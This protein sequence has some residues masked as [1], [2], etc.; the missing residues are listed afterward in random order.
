[1]GWNL[2]QL[3][4]CNNNC[5]SFR[6]LQKAAGTVICWNVYAVHWNKS[7]KDGGIAPWKDLNKNKRKEKEKQ[8]LQTCA[9]GC[10]RKREVLLQYAGI[11]MMHWNNHKDSFFEDQRWQVHLMLLQ[12]ELKAAPK[13][14]AEWLWRPPLFHKQVQITHRQWIHI[15]SQTHFWGVFNLLLIGKLE[16]NATVC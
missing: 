11:S 16:P 12:G 2:S 6:M 7:I 14:S 4:L 13:N 15:N 10:C 5:R 8:Q 9:L 1:M 3:Q